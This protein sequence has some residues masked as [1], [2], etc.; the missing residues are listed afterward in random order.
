L[1]P[2]IRDISFESIQRGIDSINVHQSGMI[3]L[4][5][6]LCIELTDTEIFIFDKR[7]TWAE[8][9]F[10][11]VEE[12]KIICIGGNENIEFGSN[13]FLK[14]Q[15]IDTGEMQ[16]QVVKSNSNVIEI[17]YFSVKNNQLKISKKESGE[18]FSPL[19]M[20][21][22]S[23]KIGEFFINEKIPKSARKNWPI[24]KELDGKIIWVMGLRISDDYK[25]TPET[26]KILRFEMV[27]K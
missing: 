2:S 8:Q 3:H 12:E 16:Y 19:G 18:R 11:Q 6:N 21:N 20:G 24:L 22:S 13:W 23:I 25:V 10:P 1:Q 15:L 9:F 17:D 26:K 4:E 14:T 27:Q 7:I 5:G